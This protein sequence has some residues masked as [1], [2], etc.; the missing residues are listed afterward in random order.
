MKGRYGRTGEIS[1]KNG[2]IVRGPGSR[3]YMGAEGCCQFAAVGGNLERGGHQ[4]RVCR[5]LADDVSTKLISLPF[6]NA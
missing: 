2:I 3:G 1:K 5:K 6:K 4:G